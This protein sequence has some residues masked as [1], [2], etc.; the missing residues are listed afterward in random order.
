MKRANPRHRRGGGLAKCRCRAQSI[1]PSTGAVFSRS[2]AKRTLRP[3]M[4]GLGRMQ[5]ANTG[6]NEVS[7]RRE[8]P[9]SGRD[10]Q[11]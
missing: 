5:V 10:K 1:D 2:G 8:P 9:P 11:R 3:K 7:M 4:L 6:G